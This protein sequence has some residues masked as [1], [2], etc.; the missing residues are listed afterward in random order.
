MSRAHPLRVADYLQHILEAI[1]S[2][3][4]YTTGMDLAGFMADRKSSLLRF[5]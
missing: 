1:G 5:S 4:E 3:Q 2:I